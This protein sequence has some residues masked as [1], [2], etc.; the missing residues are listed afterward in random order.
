MPFTP[1]ALVKVF[2]HFFAFCLA[3]VS[4]GNLGLI[5]LATVQVL[6]LLVFVMSTYKAKC[7]S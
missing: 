5:R 4:D 7:S 2:A 1:G 3:P 6:T